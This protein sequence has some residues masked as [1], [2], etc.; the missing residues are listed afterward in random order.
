[1]VRGLIAVAVISF[2]LSIA[3]FGSSN[4]VKTPTP[5]PVS[6][7]VPTPTATPSGP[8]T[9]TVQ[10]GDTLSA[11]AQKFDTTVAAIQEANKIENPDLISVGQVLVIPQP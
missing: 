10:P 3:C 7:R 6:T 9:Y 4:P 1:M 2:L 8:I 5:S 11:I